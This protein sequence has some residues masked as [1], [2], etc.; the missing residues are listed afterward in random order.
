M[1]PRLHKYTEDEAWD[2]VVANYVI[3]NCHPIYK[4]AKELGAKQSDIKEVL[5]MMRRAFNL[6]GWLAKKL[7]PKYDVSDFM[8]DYI[9]L[10]IHAWL[11]SLSEKELDGLANKTKEWSGRLIKL[12]DHPDIK[13]RLD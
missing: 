13:K 7:G 9:Y 3:I 2:S 5:G 4:K 10:W 8:M 11:H 1:K 6:E 12:L